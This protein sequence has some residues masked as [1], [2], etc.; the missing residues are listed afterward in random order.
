[1]LDIETSSKFEKDLKKAKKRQKDFSK[2]KRVLNLL[3]EQEELPEKYKDH[4]L[5][6]NWAG[7]RD[8]HIEPDWLLLYKVEEG[9]LY[10]ARTGT[11]SDLF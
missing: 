9:T 2:L 5:K 4:A 3:V 10:L 11:H 8:L 6:G 7:Y 1:M